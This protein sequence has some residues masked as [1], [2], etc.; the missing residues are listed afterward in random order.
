MDEIIG[1]GTS[2]TSR[3]KPTHK[4][5][6]F[7]HLSNEAFE[8]SLYFHPPIL[9]SASVFLNWPRRPYYYV[10]NSI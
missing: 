5:I 8:Y 4:W 7:G 6:S 2:A 1:T 9:Y 10:W 3:T